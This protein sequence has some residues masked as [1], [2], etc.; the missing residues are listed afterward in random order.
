MCVSYQELVGLFDEWSR[1]NVEYH[2]WFEEM[3]YDD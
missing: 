1:L 3:V 2:Y